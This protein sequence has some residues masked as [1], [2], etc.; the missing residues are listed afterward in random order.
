MS[1]EN[2]IQEYPI[3]AVGPLIYREDGKVLL[4]RG[5]KFG[6]Y[7]TI[8]GGKVAVGETVEEALRREVK[9]ELEMDAPKFAVKTMFIAVGECKTDGLFFPIGD[10]FDKI[11][12]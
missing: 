11:V 6:E 1:E 12:S 4:I 9:E 8:P 5:P 10:G 3:V 7:W 2:K